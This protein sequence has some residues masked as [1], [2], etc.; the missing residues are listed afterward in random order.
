MAVTIT[1]SPL[2]NSSAYQCFKWTLTIDDIGASN[3]TK[4]IGYQLFDQDDNAVTAEEVI[5]VAVAGATVELDF[6]GDVQGYVS[7]MLPFADVPNAVPDPYCIRG[8]YLMYGDVVYDSDTCTTVNNIVTPS[9]AKYVINGVIQ[10]YEPDYYNTLPSVITHLP[11]NTVQCRDA[12]NFTWVLTSG[13]GAIAEYTS[14]LGTVQSISLGSNKVVAIPLHPQ[15]ILSDWDTID[16]MDVVITE[17]GPSFDLGTFRIVFTDVCCGGGKY[18]NVLYLDPLGGRSMISFEQVETFE[19]STSFTELCRYKPCNVVGFDEADNANKMTVGGRS[20]YNKVAQERITL[21]KE[22]SYQEDVAEQ[23]KAFLAST[24]YHVQYNDNGVIK[25][26]KFIVDSGTA[27]Y[28]SAEG[29]IELRVTGYL[30]HD[31]M[32]QRQDR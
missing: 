7:T 17:S 11:R 14:S 2:A 9:A 26:R 29:I 10:E 12:R 5:G 13:A 20:I 21:V 30:A 28:N 19:L 4:K 23:F 15:E 22:S 1:A 24:G 32:T 8:F 18:S 27:V 6:S 16:Y 3:I 25:F 31:Y